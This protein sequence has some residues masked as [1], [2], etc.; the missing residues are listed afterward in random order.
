M[1]EV[2]QS[3]RESA[4]VNKARVKFLVEEKGHTVDDPN[5]DAT[6]HQSM[7]EVQD[8]FA[9]EIDSLNTKYRIELTR[10]MFPVITKNMDDI[11]VLDY[12][13]NDNP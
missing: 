1:R 8:K 4:T 2:A 6:V 7:A 12:L 5:S 9:N 10:S 3:L 11:A 13:N